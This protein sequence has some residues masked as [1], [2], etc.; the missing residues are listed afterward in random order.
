MITPCRRCKHAYSQSLS[1]MNSE[2]PTVCLIRAREQ[3][4]LKSRSPWWQNPCENIKRRCDRFAYMSTLVGLISNSRLGTLQ[5][6]KEGRKVRKDFRQGGRTYSRDRLAAVN[7]RL[8]AADQH[9]T[10]RIATSPHDIQPLTMI[11]RRR[12]RTGHDKL[13][14]K[15]RAAPMQLLMLLSR[16]RDVDWT[17]KTIPSTQC[18]L[19]SRKASFMNAGDECTSTA[20]TK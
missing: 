15:H 5:R 14:E 9:K 6:A 17:T 19:D 7:L 16:R 1:T 18:G 13:L 4:N 12:R 11:I 10:L 8:D 20:P 3:R 2:Q